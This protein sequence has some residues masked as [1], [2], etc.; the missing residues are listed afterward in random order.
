[1][2]NNVEQIETKRYNSKLIQNAKYFYITLSTYVISCLLY[3]N[4]LT[5]SYDYLLLWLFNFV[6]SIFGRNYFVFYYYFSIYYN[7]TST[8][9]Y[10]ESIIIYYSYVVYDNDYVERIFLAPKEI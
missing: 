9:I 8:I 10:I 1:M 2:I 4:K 5:V 3:I 6:L 7:K